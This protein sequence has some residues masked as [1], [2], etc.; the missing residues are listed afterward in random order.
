[1]SETE[2]LIAVLLKQQEIQ[3]QQQEILQQQHAEQLKALQQQNQQLLAVLTSNT[4][5]SSSPVTNFPTF[6]PFD[7]TAELWTDYWSRFNTFIGAHSIPATKVAQVFLTNQSNVTY[8]LLSSYA[9]QMTPPTDVNKLTIETI[10]E[11]MKSQFDPTVYL[12]RERYKFW[13]DLQR[14]PG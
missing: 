14:R 2:K 9:S 8:K 12:V 6:S 5:E 1:M 10:S 13:S 11:Y 3:Q 4:K 7:S